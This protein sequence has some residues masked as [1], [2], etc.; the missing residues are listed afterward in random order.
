MLVLSGLGI[1]VLAGLIGGLI[2]PAW[3]FVDCLSSKQIAKNHKTFWTFVLGL[4]PFIGL[5][6]P[7]QAR[8]W[9]LSFSAGQV[10]PGLVALISIIGA[11]IYAFTESKNRWLRRFAT[12]VTTASIL[13]VI[14]FFAGNVASQ[15]EGMRVNRSVALSLQRATLTQLTEKDRR[16]ALVTLDQLDQELQRVNFFDEPGRDRLIEIATLLQAYLADGGLDKVELDDWLKT[17]SERQTLDL[18][19]LKRRI[20][21]IYSA[22]EAPAGPEYRGKNK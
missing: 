6:W 16:S 9:G 4:G 14:L 21:D 11:I 12:V 5:L 2:L 7:L 10:I 22:A 13:S 20:R 1:I 18:R 15:N 19:T 17:Y 3:A 8:S